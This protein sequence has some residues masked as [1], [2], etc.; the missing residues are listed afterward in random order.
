MVLQR[1]HTVIT[2]DVA[3]ELNMLGMLLA[4]LCILPPVAMLVVSV[5]NYFKGK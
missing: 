4:G 5:V 3:H 2:A 1:R